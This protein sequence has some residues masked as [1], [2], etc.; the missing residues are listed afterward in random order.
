LRAT[1][2]KI[3]DLTGRLGYFDGLEAK[4]E[5]AD[6]FREDRLRR[7]LVGGWKKMVLVGGEGKG[8]V[9][10]DKPSIVWGKMKEFF[11]RWRAGHVVQ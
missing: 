6:R 8:G 1:R 9:K 5:M 10:G 7:E 4:M 2:R 3:G 11:G